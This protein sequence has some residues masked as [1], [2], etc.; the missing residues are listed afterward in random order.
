MSLKTFGT[1]ATTSLSAINYSQSP[2]VNIGQT[3]GNSATASADMASLNALVKDDLNQTGNYSPNKFF[4]F[5][6]LLM[7]PRRGL[8]RVLPGDY[9]AVDSTTGWPILISAAAIASGPWSHN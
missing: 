2:L 4:D 1:N 5:N 6:G 7:I 8:V 3:A 9:I